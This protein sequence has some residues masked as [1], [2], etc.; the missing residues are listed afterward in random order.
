MQLLLKKG[1]GEKARPRPRRVFSLLYI[2]M[3]DP[4]GVPK[5]CPARPLFVLLAGWG[6]LALPLK[7]KEKGGKGR[8]KATLTILLVQQVALRGNAEIFLAFAHF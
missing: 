6:G 3:D 1:D 4:F 2:S 8:I 5:K 7:K